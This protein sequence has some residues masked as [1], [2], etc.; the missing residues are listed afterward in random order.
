MD[1]A[2]RGTAEHVVNELKTLGVRVLNKA[3][4]VADVFDAS[5][6]VIR[7]YYRCEY[8]YK[9]AVAS[10]IVFGRHSPRTTGLAIEL[11][12]A[13]SIVD[14]AVFNGTSTA[15]EIKTEYDSDRRLHTQTSSYLKAFDRV[16]IVTD[17]RNAERYA[18][19]ADQRVGVLI[20]NRRGSFHEFRG[21]TSDISR[22]EPTEIFRM[23][24]QS[25]YI[26][27]VHRH[28]GLQPAMPNALIGSYYYSLFKQLSS[29]QAH[30]A[31]VSAIRARSVNTDM[32]SF[33][34]ALP[35]S[36]RALGY[37][38]PLSRPQRHRVLE[39]LVASA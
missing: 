5:F 17:R 7:K 22:I 27:A 31:L 1:I 38:T 28:F 26:G 36:L 10:R 6:D 12:V 37:A 39:A 2:R 24:R 35:T 8:V 29:A 20:L 9:T 25:E 34:L 30:Q 11:G 13:G 33:L 3:A 16:Y 23:L 4:T 21:A 14:A 15:Y 19:L 18:S 32:V